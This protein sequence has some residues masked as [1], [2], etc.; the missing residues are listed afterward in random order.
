LNE[1]PEATPLF[2]GFGPLFPFSFSGLGGL[3]GFSFF[4][5]F[6]LGSPFFLFFGSGVFFAS[7][8]CYY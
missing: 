3:G 8:L 5:F 4:S 2:F 6:S 1:S 7:A